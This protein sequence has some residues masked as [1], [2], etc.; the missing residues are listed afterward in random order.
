MLKP[1]DGGFGERQHGK[2]RPQR[3]KTGYQHIVGA[4]FVDDCGH[5]RGHGLIEL[6]FSWLASHGW[7]V[8]VRGVGYRLVDAA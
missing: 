1:K 8:S 4:R 6:A 2:L 7:I 3:Q 5:A